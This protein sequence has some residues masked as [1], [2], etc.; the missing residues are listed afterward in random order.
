MRGA[1]ALAQNLN[2]IRSDALLYKKLTTLR[3]DVPISESLED[4]RWRGIPTPDFR[5]F[6]ATQ[7]FTRLAE[8]DLPTPHP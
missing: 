8:S 5:D 2:D 4:L 6:C 7:G 1:K 3:T